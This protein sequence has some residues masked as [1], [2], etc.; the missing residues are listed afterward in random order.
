MPP[1]QPVY[2]QRTNTI[3]AIT[4][5][6]LRTREVLDN[7]AVLIGLDL[8]QG[9]LHHRPSERHHSNELTRTVIFHTRCC[10]HVFDSELYKNIMER[11]DERSEL[12]AFGG[13]ECR[14][15]RRI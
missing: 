3:D 5:Y 2:F 7:V 10:G 8:D 12:T 4:M 13:T 1:R 9:H 6:A 15:R 14:G 11:G